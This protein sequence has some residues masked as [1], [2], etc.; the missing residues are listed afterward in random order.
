[1]PAQQALSIWKG[2]TVSFPIR[3]Q[4]RNG[5]TLTPVD[6]SGSVLVFRAS[7]P[8][9]SLR[10][11]EAEQGFAITS[12]PQGEATLAFTIEETR[13]LPVGSVVRYEIERRIGATQTTLLYGELKVSEWVN[14]D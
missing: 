12:A 3:I 11:E 10:K 13:R 14:D 2:N 8:G 4:T 6:L 1:M 5:A 9:G 7:W